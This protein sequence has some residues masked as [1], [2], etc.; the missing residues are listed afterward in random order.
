MRII[1]IEIDKEKDLT[2]VEKFLDDL[3]LKYHLDDLEALEKSIQT[4]YS[5]SE[6]GLTRPHTQVMQEFIDKYK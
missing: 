1:T 6:K 5:Q 4:G 2:V 3:G